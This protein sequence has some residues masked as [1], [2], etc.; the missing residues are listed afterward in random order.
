MNGWFNVGYGVVVCG[1]QVFHQKSGQNNVH[2][3]IHLSRRVD[4]R[5]GKGYQDDQDQECDESPKQDWFHL[6]STNI[7]FQ[8]L[9]PHKFLCI[10]YKEQ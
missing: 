7:S 1:F 10:M 6:L 8:Y 3:F 5:N 9:G 2:S 4:V